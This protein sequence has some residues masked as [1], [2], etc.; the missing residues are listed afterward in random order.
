MDKVTSLAI[1]AVARVQKN[2][3]LFCLVFAVLPVVLSQLVRAMGELT[4][5]TIRTYSFFHKFFA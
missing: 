4:S 1:F 3:A 2:H 5:V